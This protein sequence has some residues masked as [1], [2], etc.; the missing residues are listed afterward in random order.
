[1][2]WTGNPLPTLLGIE[3]TQQVTVKW[4]YEH[5]L[6]HQ[7]GL[8]GEDSGRVV[9]VHKYGQDWHGPSGR[10]NAET[11]LWGAEYQGTDLVMAPAVW[12]LPTEM[13]ISLGFSSQC[14]CKFHLRKQRLR[15]G[16]GS[17][18]KTYWLES[19]YTDSAQLQK[20]TMTKGGHFK[21]TRFPYNH[22][23]EEL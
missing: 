6:C 3:E 11:K 17:V 21:G 16:S 2:K 1:M 8:K 4:V 18:G 15:S 13:L 20:K 12:K 19:G 23:V 9:P 14:V 5:E 10:E 22:L 7:E